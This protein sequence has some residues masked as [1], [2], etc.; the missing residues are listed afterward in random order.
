[1]SKTRTQDAGKTSQAH[2]LPIAGYSGAGL[3]GSSGNRVINF[4]DENEL[5]AFLT[6]GAGRMIRSFARDYGIEDSVSSE[7]DGEDYDDYEQVEADF[8]DDSTDIADSD[9]P[10]DD[11][12]YYYEDDEDEYEIVDEE[13]DF[14]DTHGEI[15]IWLDLLLAESM[16]DGG[17]DVGLFPDSAQGFSEDSSQPSST[18]DDDSSFERAV[19]ALQT[20][21]FADHTDEQAAAM[22]CGTFPQT[23]IGPSSRQSSSTRRMSLRLSVIIPRCHKLV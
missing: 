18:T 2:S 1:M 19:E 13:G 12:D 23:Y 15:E 20:V 9:D 3:V 17:L 21:S 8:S 14:D 10:D 5:H 6:D 16:M 7:A 11:D 22:H 4:R